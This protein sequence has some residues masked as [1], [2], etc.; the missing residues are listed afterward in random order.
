MALTACS[1][2]P[3]FGAFLAVKFPTPIEPWDLFAAVAMHALI[4]DTRR[5]ELLLD[6]AQKD[7][8]TVAD[9]VAVVAAAYADAMERERD[10][11]D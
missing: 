1:N 7:G 11:E 5:F 6:Q 10:S 4:V 8:T 3:N 9:E 2:H